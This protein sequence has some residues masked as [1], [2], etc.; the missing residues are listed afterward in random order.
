VSEGSRETP[1]LAQMQTGIMREGLVEGV[2]GLV[3]ELGLHRARAF[4]VSL[5]I[6]V[7]LRDTSVC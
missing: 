3:A 6:R 4:R 2:A 1:N 7:L 5:T